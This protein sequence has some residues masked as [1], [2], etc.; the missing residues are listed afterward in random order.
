MSH[1][2]AAILLNA[3][4][5]DEM[6]EQWKK[7]PDTV[8]PGWAAFFQGFELGLSRTPAPAAAPSTD[9]F[10]QIGITRLIVAYRS[11]GHLIAHTNPLS[12]PPNNHPLLDLDQFM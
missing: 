1:P 3:D 11:I 4:L 7:A 9:A 12:P 8:E 2:S 10:R 5:F 6:Y